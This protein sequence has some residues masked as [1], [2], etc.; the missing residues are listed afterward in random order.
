MVGRFCMIPHSIDLTKCRLAFVQCAVE[1][2]FG[3][4]E[5]LAAKLELSRSTLSRFFN[6]RPT[7]LPTAL[8]IL[9]A[10]HVRFEDVATPETTEGHEPA[11][12]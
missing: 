1:G 9:Q 5:E 4:I 2:E 11:D 12:H 8:A 10:L 3:S 6:G 7:S